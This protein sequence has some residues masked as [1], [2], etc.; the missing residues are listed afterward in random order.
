MI[1]EVAVET[2]ADLGAELAFR[3]LE[4]RLERRWASRPKDGTKSLSLRR[5]F[6][7]WPSN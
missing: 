1:P 4:W 5:G 6:I 2:A 3:I 7:G